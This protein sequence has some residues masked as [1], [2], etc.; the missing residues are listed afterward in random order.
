MKTYALLLVLTLTA[1]P[2]TTL[3]AAKPPRPNILYFYV[4]DMGW[5][6]IG[7]NG[8][9]ARKAKNLPY[10]RT[11]TLDR[12]AAHGVPAAPRS[13]PGHA[14]AASATSGRRS[15]PPRPAKPGLARQRRRALA[16][17]EPAS[18]QCPGRPTRTSLGDPGAQPIFFCECPLT[19]M[20]LHR[21]ISASVPS[22]F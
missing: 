9:A 21:T 8:Q 14:R 10:V 19:A 2:A 22:A 1:V 7:P 16:N 6:S 12:L 20:G 4:D 3:A 11:P 17:R 13:A 18:S 15:C 5:G